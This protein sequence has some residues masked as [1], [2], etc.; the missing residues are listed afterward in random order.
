MDSLLDTALAVGFAFTTSLARQTQ[1]EARRA[2]AH[3]FKLDFDRVC[4]GVVHCSSFKCSAMRA[5]KLEEPELQ[6]ETKVS[7]VG[8][9][10]AHISGLS[11]S[12]PRL[13]FKVE[14][15][16]HPASAASPAASLPQWGPHA[17]VSLTGY[18][19]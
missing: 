7:A 11:L 2:L 18:H 14:A 4:H 17:P 8:T 9:L 12:G 1:A 16:L 6:T 5:L 15:L 13:L 3:D 10:N 19:R